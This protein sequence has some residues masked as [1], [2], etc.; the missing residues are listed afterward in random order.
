MIL[1]IRGR[2]TLWYVLLLFLTLTLFS[3]V[4]ALGANRSLHRWFDHD[5]SQEVLQFCGESEI[6]DDGELDLEYEVLSHGEHVAAYDAHGLLVAQFRA[7]AAAGPIALVEGFDTFDIQGIPWRRLTVYAPNIK[8]WIQVSRTQEDIQASL[9]ALSALLFLGVPVTVILAGAGGLFL[10][11]RMLNPLDQITRKAAELG[12]ERLAERLEPLETRDELG[13]LVETFNQM[14]GRLDDAFERQKQF[15]SDA[16]HELRT[17]IA[18]LL[19]RAE[20]ALSRPRDSAEYQA[21]LVE[22]RDGLEAMTSLVSKLLT[23][24][25]AD[26]GAALLDR[27]PLDLAELV[28]DAVGSLR[29]EQSEVRWETHLA[30]TPVTGD[31]TRLTELVLN[32]LENALRHGA[33]DGVIQVSTRQQLGFCVLSVQDSG[34]GVPEDLREKIFERFYQAETSRT[35]EGAGLGLSISRAIVAQHGGEIFLQSEP[36]VK[37]A[38]FVVRLPLRSTATGPGL[39]R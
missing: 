18:R 33:P 34:P 19:T 1:G 22:M 17:P 8:L 30:S 31:Q 7:P 9:Q 10:A 14:L 20:V 36:G 39:P 15:T 16:A 27:E 26:S 37:G 12:V 23:L 24:A 13:R 4:I 38:H 2:L 6:E 5:L 25:R 29:E 35:G 3:A 11:S 28:S 32:L 21:T